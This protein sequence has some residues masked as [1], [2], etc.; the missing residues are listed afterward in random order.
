MSICKVLS[1]TKIFKNDVQ[2]NNLQKVLKID[3]EGQFAN[4]KD[5]N[6]VRIGNLQNKMFRTTNCKI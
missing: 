5:K 6:V 1:G 2:N 4:E 3:P